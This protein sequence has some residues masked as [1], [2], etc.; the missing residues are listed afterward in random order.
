[1]ENQDNLKQQ[2]IAFDKAG[3]KQKAIECFLKAAENG[4]K[5]C[6]LYAGKICQFDLHDEQKAGPLFVKAA[7]GGVPRSFNYASLA[8]KKG[9][10]VSIDLAKAEEFARKG[11]EMGDFYCAYNLG[12]WYSSGELGQ[13]DSQKAKEAFQFARDS[14]GYPKAPKEAKDRIDSYLD[15]PSEPAKP[16]EKKSSSENN[17][18]TAFYIT[19]ALLGVAGVVL[20]SF[21]C[22]Q[23]KQPAWFGLFAL[24]VPMIAYNVMPFV[25]KKARNSV[26]YFYI[27]LGF[28]LLYIVAILVA[29]IMWQKAKG[30]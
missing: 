30:L 14:V 6:Y 7:E 27:D 19:L 26:L 16:E 29:A 23:L 3:E 1:M 15:S 21:A 20:A 4:D 12:I 8:C 22:A 9:N 17:W 28:A 10:G 11:M 25:F 5:V 13:A 2:G 24:F 18:I